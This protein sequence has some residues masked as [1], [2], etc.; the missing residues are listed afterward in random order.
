MPLVS[1]HPILC[2]VNSDLYC[3][4]PSLS[5]EKEFLKLFCIPSAPVFLSRLPQASLHPLG[6]IYEPNFHSRLWAPSSGRGCFPVHLCLPVAHTLWDTWKMPNE[7]GTEE[8]W[9]IPGQEASQSSREHGF[10]RDPAPTRASFSSG[11]T[12]L[13]S[14]NVSFSSPMLKQ[15]QQGK[16]ICG[17][18]SDDF[19][20]CLYARC[21]WRG[22]SPLSTPPTCH[23][24][25]L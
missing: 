24:A 16:E 11:G 20:Y 7:Q 15:K 9:P 3:W 1:T 6:M 18:P 21:P 5:I 2:L 14:Q 8:A 10:P 22:Q 17:N 25:P 23:M 19:P 4:E 13:H 12:R